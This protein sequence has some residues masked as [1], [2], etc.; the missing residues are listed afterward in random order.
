MNHLGDFFLDVR[1]FGSPLDLG[2]VADGPGQHIHQTRLA[3]TVVGPVV[4]GETINNGARKFGFTIEKYLFVG[5]KY[6]LKDNNRF[7]ADGSEPRLAA[8]NIF[9][10][11]APGIV[12]LAAEYHGD[13]LGIDRN[14]TYDGIIS[15]LVIQGRGRH[16]QNFMGVDRT[17]HV[18]LRATDIDTVRGTLYHPHILIRVALGSG[19]F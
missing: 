10:V 6:V 3:G 12:G 13:P 14:R 1:S 17:R 11:V 5:H 2:K 18:Q 8:V 15:G 4:G 9:Q 7:S 16:H 19:T